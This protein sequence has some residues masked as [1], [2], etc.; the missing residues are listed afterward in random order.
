M[1]DIHVDDVTSGPM[2]NVG[3][4]DQLMNAIQVRLDDQY[5]KTR[6][7]GGDYAQ[8]YLGAMQ[9][10]LQQSIHFL[11]QE[12]ISDAQ[13]ELLKQ[14]KLTEVQNTLKVTAETALV[15]Q[16]TAIATQDELLRAAQV[17]TEGEKYNLTVAQT[18]LTT[19]QKLKTD[20]EELLVDQ[21]LLT[22][23]QQTS[24]VQQEVA[25]SAAQTALLTQQE[26]TETQ[27]YQK[28]CV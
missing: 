26:L 18:A 14:Q 1:S 17:L 16:Q 6:L 27:N 13:A 3:V 2:D 5:Q 12:Q 23:V 25:K 7:R 9:T 20:A 22:E 19:S 8:V 24:L 15:T 28:C 4:F 10:V 11:L 21:K